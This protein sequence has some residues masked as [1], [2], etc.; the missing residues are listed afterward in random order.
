MTSLTRSLLLAGALLAVAA[1]RALAGEPV[2][3]LRSHYVVILEG[4]DEPA[5]LVSR[6]VRFPDEFGSTEYFLVIDREDH[7]FILTNTQDYMDHV[8]VRE[9]KDIQHDAFIRSK[10]QLPTHSK[11]AE[12]GLRELRENNAMLPTMPFT[13]ETGA[14]SITAPRSDWKNEVT[15]NPWRLQIRRALDPFLL[16]SIEEMRETLFTDQLNTEYLGLARYFLFD[17]SCME[18][19]QG[20]LREIPLDCSF[21]ASFGM[22]CS[23]EEK[24]QQADALARGRSAPLPIFG[25]FSPE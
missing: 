19:S 24:K 9:I 4:L 11:N 18:H 21:D 5:Y 12:D 25:N 8:S 17:E 22:E 13:I 10:L 16:E 1:P 3:E 14:V 15:S 20:S 2:R 6:I 23:D 7:R